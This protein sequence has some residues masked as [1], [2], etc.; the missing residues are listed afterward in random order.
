MAFRLTEADVGDEIIARI[1][2]SGLVTE[3]AVHVALPPINA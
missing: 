2:R 3:V 1:D